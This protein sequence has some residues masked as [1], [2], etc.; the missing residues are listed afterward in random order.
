MTRYTIKFS[1]GGTIIEPATDIQ[2]A[3][4]SAQMSRLLIAYTTGV[5]QSREVIE[6]KKEDE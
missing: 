4:T 1:D 5:Q 2:S 3:I 6:A